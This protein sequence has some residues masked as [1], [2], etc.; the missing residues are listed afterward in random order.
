MTRAQ[1][2]LLLVVPLKFHLTQQSRQGDGHVYGARSRFLTDKVQKTLDPV[3]F[4]SAT[5]GGAD[6]LQEAQE[7]VAVDVGARLRDMW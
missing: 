5:L 2:D 4:H 1:N 7:P 3:T 6:A